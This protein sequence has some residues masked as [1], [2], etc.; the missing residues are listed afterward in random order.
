MLSNEFRMGRPGM[1]KGRAPGHRSRQRGVVLI[2]ALIV[3]VALTLAAVALTRS[4]GT[5][6]SI[7]GNLAFQQAATHSADRGVEAA[8]KWLED[9]VNEATGCSSGS[10]VACDQT[11]KGYL[12]ARTDPDTAS[13]QSWGEFWTKALITKATPVDISDASTGNKVSYIIQRMCETTGEANTS[14]NV[15]ATAPRAVAGSCPGGTSCTGGGGRGGTGSNV[16]SPKQTYY[17]ITVI[18]NG[19]RNTQSM[20]Q[21][22]VAI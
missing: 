22:M 20:V 8:V 16:D 14:A 17:R 2:L 7:A 6:N 15:C 5:S 11:A 10:A 13:K 18:V 4:V 3:L 19:P 12:A 9:N 1:S 21:A